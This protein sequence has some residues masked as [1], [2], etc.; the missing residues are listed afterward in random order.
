MERAWSLLLG[1][2]DSCGS[3]FSEL[4]GSLAVTSLRLALM[5]SVLP[6]YSTQP[7]LLLLYSA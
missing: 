7:N 4:E 3:S 5:A 2:C 1:T 6:F